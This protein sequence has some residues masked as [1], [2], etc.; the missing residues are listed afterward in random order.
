MS[1][2]VVYSKSFGVKYKSS[3][4]SKAF[5]LYAIISLLTFILPFIFCY[6]SNGK[7]NIFT[8]FRIASQCTIFILKFKISGLWLKYEKYREQPR[9]QFKLQYLLYAETSD[10]TSSLI[11]GNFP[12]TLNTIDFCSTVKV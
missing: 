8:L 12:R 5:I 10:P 1:V 9:V 11:C 3:I 7:L 4:C 6:R 2:Y